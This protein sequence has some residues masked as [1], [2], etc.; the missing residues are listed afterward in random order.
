MLTLPSFLF[1]IES[2]ES[3]GCFYGEVLAVVHS[4]LTQLDV[5][6]RLTSQK[7]TTQKRVGAQSTDHTQ[8]I[9]VLRTAAQ[10]H[11]H[12]HTHTPRVWKK[13]ILKSREM[14]QGFRAFEKPFNDLSR[15]ID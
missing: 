12:T 8:E 6:Q 14:H 15:D 10:T 2:H 11:M 4:L 1:A 5:T 7:H 9:S 13:S 3:S